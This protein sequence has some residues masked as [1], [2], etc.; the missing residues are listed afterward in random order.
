MKVT[1]GHSIA[2]DP[3]E[4]SGIYDKF[5]FCDKCEGTLIRIYRDVITGELFGE[6][7]DQDYGIRD[8]DK[9]EIQEYIRYMPKEVFK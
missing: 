2:G 8:L 5:E 4:N 6:E 1:K 7:V 9:E 3:N